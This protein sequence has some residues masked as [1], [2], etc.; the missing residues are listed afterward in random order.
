M[1]NTVTLWLGLALSIP[2]A[3]LVNLITPT[4][5][6]F[7]ASVNADQRRKLQKIKERERVFAETLSTNQ[8]AV[9][10]YLI[11]KNNLTTRHLFFSLQFLIMGMFL[12][13][14]GRFYSPIH[15]SPLF[16][17][18]VNI[19]GLTSTVLCPIEAVAALNEARKLR[20]VQD[21]ILSKDDALNTLELP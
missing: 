4:L 8:T 14:V 5:H 2:I 20:Y 7:I 6:I 15:L 1:T 21:Y 12:I 16:R 10:A 9:M 17:W 18:A 3:I 13:V 19:G 11:T